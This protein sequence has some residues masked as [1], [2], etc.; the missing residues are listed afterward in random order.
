M[1]E[2][3]KIS[4]RNHLYLLG[5]TA[6][7]ALVSCTPG[8][9]VDVAA[10]EAQL[11]DILTKIQQGVKDR[12]TLVPTATSVLGVLQALAGSNVGIAAF[13][14]VLQ[15]A[16]TLITKACPQSSTTTTGPGSLTVNANG[17]DVVIV[18]Y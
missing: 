7:L 2:A 6:A 16:I 13:L 1:N 5:G 18:F 14:A 15:G 10:L 3:N 4:R 17:K 11:A 8:Q 9:Q 12:C